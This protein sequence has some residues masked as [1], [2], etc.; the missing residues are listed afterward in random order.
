MTRQI[1]MSNVNAKRTFFDLFNTGKPVLKV[2]FN[3]NSEEEATKIQIENK[4]ERK[5]DTRALPNLQKVC[6]D[7][8][9]SDFFDFYS[10]Y[11][12]F[13]LGMPI[14]PKNSVKKTLIRQLQI[15]E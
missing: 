8:R 1:N 9:L 10:K 11:N 12:G 5:A 7:I 14:F 13:R 15:S 2:K 4:I 3:I 6:T